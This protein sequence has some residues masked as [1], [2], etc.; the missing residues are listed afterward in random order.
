MADESAL[1]SSTAAYLSEP[2]PEPYPEWFRIGPMRFAYEYHWKFGKVWR[3][4][5]N[6]AQDAPVTGPTDKLFLIKMEA[7]GSGGVSWMAVHAPGD[8]TDAATLLSNHK[9]VFGSTENVLERGDHYWNWFDHN[10]NQWKP[11]NQ[12]ETTWL[13]SAAT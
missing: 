5:R 3:C 11:L 10:T 7:P 9:L 6:A 4:D 8:V 13:P 2:L 12:F 1:T